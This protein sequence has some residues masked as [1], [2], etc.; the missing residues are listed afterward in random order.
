MP[1]AGK[2]FIGE[3]LADFLGFSFVDP[4]KMLEKGQ[5]RP[6]QEILDRLGESTF[7]WTEAEMSIASF[8]DAD[9]IVLATGG[10]IVY[11]E[12]VMAKFARLSTIIYLEV[13]F[14][15]LKMRIGEEPRG[16]IGLKS[17]TF[18]QLYQERVP[19]YEKW[20]SVTV[21]G[22]QEP[23]KVLRDIINTLNWR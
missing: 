23:E 20:A 16:I 18:L 9:H 3:K 21:N 1:G 7:L 14:E 11:S 19:L 15:A 4:D 6:L 10:S 5:G 13:A 22:S 2:S 17:K 8:D 12:D